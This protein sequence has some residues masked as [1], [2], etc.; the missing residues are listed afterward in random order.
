MFSSWKF[1]W[2]L[3]SNARSVLPFSSSVFEAV[4]FASLPG[5]S[6]Y[7]PGFGD[8]LARWLLPSPERF[9]PDHEVSE[10]KKIYLLAGPNTMLDVFR[11]QMIYEL[12]EHCL[13][14][15]G[16]VFECGT[17][18]GGLSLLMA[19]LIRAR[20]LSKRVW[21]FD[22]FEGLP[23]P[24]RSVDRAYQAGACAYRLDR[25][26]ALMRRHGVEDLVEIRKGW[27]SDSLSTLAADERFCFGHVDV[28]LYGSTRTAISHMYSR[29]CDG[30]PIVFDDYCDGSGGVFKAVNEA[31]RDLNEVVHLG[32]TCQ[33]F[34][35]KGSSGPTSWV[36]EGADASG[37]ALS[38]SAN[39]EYLRRSTGYLDFLRAMQK[40]LGKTRLVCLSPLVRGLKPLTTR[41]VGE[42]LDSYLAL[43][44]PRQPAG[45]KR[46]V[47]EPE[48][49][50]VFTGNIADCSN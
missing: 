8:R 47:L 18:P 16:D 41:S 33:A 20:G 34:F 38:V 7:K 39:L 9:A 17:G 19:L 2:G 31:A 49:T 29:V 37:G 4:Q 50:L 36:V 10:F 6:E 11:A 44:K 27:L 35:I 23:F 28:D 1:P 22:S 48:G 5:F 46:F 42:S 32:P 21:I 14:K 45:E 24:D 25:V 12:L 3:K 43:F 40:A 30:C 13:K 26:Q 15:E